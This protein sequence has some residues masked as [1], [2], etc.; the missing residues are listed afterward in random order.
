MLLGALWSLLQG[1]FCIIPLQFE[2]GLARVSQSGNELCHARPISAI[3]PVALKVAPALTRIA[4]Q[5]N[6]NKKAS[7][8]LLGRDVIDHPSIKCLAIF[9]G[10]IYFPLF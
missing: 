8:I 4:L 7:P 3:A 9:W 10:S 2:L 1:M 5:Q 6:P